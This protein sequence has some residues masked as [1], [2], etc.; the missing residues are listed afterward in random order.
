MLDIDKIKR[1]FETLDCKVEFHI[2]D[3]CVP[4]TTKPAISAFV[5]ENCGSGFLEQNP[6][7]GKMPDTGEWKIVGYCKGCN[8]KTRGM[9]SN[10]TDRIPTKYPPTPD[11]P[12]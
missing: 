9:L 3:E 10:N 8:G 11:I 12:D 6:F 2:V 7:I 5:C 1:F 4:S